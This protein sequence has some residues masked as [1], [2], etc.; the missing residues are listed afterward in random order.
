VLLWELGPARDA[1]AT[2]TAEGCSIRRLAGP[3]LDCLVRNPD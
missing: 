2:D 3:Q 1:G